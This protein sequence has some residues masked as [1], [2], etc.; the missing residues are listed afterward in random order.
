MVAS[1]AAQT[2]TE[3]SSSVSFKFSATK[4]KPRHFSIS[5]PDYVPKPF[6]PSNAVSNFRPIIRVADWLDRGLAVRRQKLSHLQI[7]Q[8]GYCTFISAELA[9]RRLYLILKIP[10]DR[11]DAFVKKIEIP[12]P[13]HEAL[14][15]AVFER[16]IRDDHFERIM[17]VVARQIAR[18][19]ESVSTLR[20]MK[21]P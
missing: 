16:Q 9:Y 10:L 8:I 3:M 20:Q 2:E 4:S 15:K 11:Y 13:A 19:E 18:A 21:N 6:P 17:I 7:D 14:R 5:Q 1:I 12:S